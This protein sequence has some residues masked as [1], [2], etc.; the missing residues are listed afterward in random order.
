MDQNQ[1]ADLKGQ[2]EELQAKLQTAEEQQRI[3]QEE[4]APLRV[5]LEWEAPERIFE[6]RS[7]VW[8]L[9]V[10]L[11]FIV[12]IAFAAVTQEILLIIA[13]IALMFLVYLNS[14]IE[15]KLVN[16]EITNKG[17]K[18][19]EDIWLWSDIKGV[20]IGKRGKH[21]VLNVDLADGVKRSNNRLML[22]LGVANPEEIVRELIKHITYL[23]RNQVDQ[24]F[25]AVFTHGDYQPITVYIPELSANK[26]TQTNSATTVNTESKNSSLTKSK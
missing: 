23:N 17:I 15:P 18:S 6:N 8:Y 2:L 21:D 4:A 16:H 12:A 14:T 9:L 24:D 25:I 13:L 26:S 10:T 11:G 20:W 7:K 1:V 19:G 22:L 3:K 5:I